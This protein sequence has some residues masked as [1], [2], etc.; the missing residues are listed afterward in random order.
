[1]KRQ[2]AVDVGAAA[3][4]DADGNVLP[5]DSKKVY[6]PSSKDARRAVKF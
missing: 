1:M 5:F 6:L 3:M 2:Q 4:T